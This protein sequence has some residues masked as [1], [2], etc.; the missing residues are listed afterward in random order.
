MVGDASGI[1]AGRWAGSAVPGKAASAGQRRGFV[2]HEVVSKEGTMSTI[3]TTVL[4]LASVAFLAE[5]APALGAGEAQLQRDGDVRSRVAGRS[6]QTIARD[7]SDKGIEAWGAARAARADNP[8]DVYLALGA[9]SGMALAYSQLAA[10]HRS[11]DTLRPGAVTL[12]ARA[13]EIDD[14]F[15]CMTSTRAEWRRVQEQVAAL[16]DYFR[17]DYMVQRPG[18]IGEA[19]RGG[20]SPGGLFRWEGRVDGRDMILV[21][22]DRVT[23]RHLENNP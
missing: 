4:L 3:G 6:L 11:D 15:R 5:R 7:L 13:R 14:L 23:I 22:G 10:V 17:L 21:R 8:V 1:R 18:R 9:F 20:A 2:G 19:D 12:L 16:S